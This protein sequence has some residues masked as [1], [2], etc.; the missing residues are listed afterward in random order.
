[1]SDE[2][3]LCVAYSVMDNSCLST[4]EKY[5]NECIRSGWQPFG[6]ISVSY[7]NHRTH[8][9]QAMVRYA[10]ENKGTESSTTKKGLDGTI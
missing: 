6:G 5:V 3:K 8:Y 7:D 4:L 10:S 2:K 1:M 9:A